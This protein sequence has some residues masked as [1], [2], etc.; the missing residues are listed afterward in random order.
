[1][2]LTPP[3]I[4]SEMAV[5]AYS[6]VTGPYAGQA[7]P[8]APAV[9]SNPSSITNA[10]PASSSTA[11]AGISSLAQV[12]GATVKPV[13]DVD[14][15]SLTANPAY[16]VHILPDGVAGVTAFLPDAFSTSITAGYDSLLDVGKSIPLL[17]KV[18][19][20]VE[21]AGNL[22]RLGGIAPSIQ[23]MTAQVWGGSSPMALTL[24]LVF[25]LDTNTEADILQPLRSLLRLVMPSKVSRDKSGNATGTLLKSPGPKW[26]LDAGL[27][28]PDPSSRA[29]GTAGSFLQGV[30]SVIGSGV[31]TAT[32]ALTAGKIPSATD[33]ITPL[34][35]ATANVF[36]G[37]TVVDNIIVRVGEFY[38]MPFAVVKSVDQDW[39]VVLDRYTLRPT[40]VTLTVA[41]ESWMVPN[42][43]DLT[44]IFP[45]AAG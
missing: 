30:Q 10:V 5:P 3:V 29:L 8:A 25:L 35:N 4:N 18:A 19:G 36:N 12:V 27:D 44:T 26:L 20:A 24:P 1:M 2:A 13:T 14:F 9:G 23:A 43:D 6:S 34:N 28:A 15:D 37:M 45:T 33:V 17:G 16:A 32:N 22:A 40:A 7:A 11:L 21:G 42:A 39:T 38:V 31:S 41:F